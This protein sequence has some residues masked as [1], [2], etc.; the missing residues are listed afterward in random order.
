M[1]ECL[2]GKLKGERKTIQSQCKYQKLD[3]SLFRNMLRCYRT[4][5]IESSMNRKL[6]LCKWSP[7]YHRRNHLKISW[8]W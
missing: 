1:F 4:I 6:T 8:S 5:R 7:W 2:F 3:C